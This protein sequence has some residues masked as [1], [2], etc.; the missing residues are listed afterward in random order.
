M[1]LQDTVQVLESCAQEAAEP[2]KPMHDTIPAV[3]GVASP[4]PDELLRCFEEVS[5]KPA[6]N[7]GHPQLEH[8]LYRCF[9]LYHMPV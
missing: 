2:G 5:N 4:G 3:D 1:W 7:H 6:S 9:F 8:C